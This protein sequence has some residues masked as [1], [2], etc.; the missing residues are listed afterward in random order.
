VN[1]HQIEEQALADEFEQAVGTYWGRPGLAEAILESLRAAGKNLD[2]LTIDDLAPLDQFHGGGKEATL[3][4]ARAAA[5]QPHTRVLDVGGGLG[6]PART[7]VVEFDCDVTVLDLTEDYLRAGEVL[8]QRLGLADRVRFVYGNALAIPFADEHFDLIWTQNTGMHIQKKAALYQEF[9]RV[10]RPG[11]E[12]ATQE[13]AAGPIQP[14]HFP[15][16]WAR[17]A[18]TSWLAAPADQ[19]STILAA[20]FREKAWEVGVSGPSMPSQA[21]SGQTQTT[22]RHIVMGDALPEIQRNGVRNWQENRL[23]EVQGVFE[24]L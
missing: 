17:D 24:R 8:T 1:A 12:L 21:P 20:G 7:L 22:I 11:G 3:A 23:T 13:P 10:L 4:L 6:G 14:L 2:A 9:H 19:R 18:S 5:P 15:V 16:M